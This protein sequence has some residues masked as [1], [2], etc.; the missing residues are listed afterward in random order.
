MAKLV[1]HYGAK[2]S[3]NFANG[4]LDYYNLPTLEKIGSLSRLPFSVRILLESAL[5]NFDAF[6]FTEDHIKQ[7]INWN[8]TDVARKEIPYK[9]ARVVL[10]DFTG[11]PAIV[12]LAAMREAMKKMGGAPSKINPLV[13]C[14]LVID[15]SVQVDYAGR[16]DA[17]SLNEKLEFQRNKERYQ[18]LKWG[19]KAFKNLRVVPP[20]TGI[21]HQVNL[22]YLAEG[23]YLNRDKNLVYPD[24]CVGTDSHTPMVNGLGVLAWGVGGIEAEAVMLDQ[25]LYLLVPDV[26]GIKL[27]GSL[28]E[29][30]T[31]TDLVLKITEVCRKIGVVDKFVEFFG[32]GLESLSV[33]DRATIGNMAPE[34]GSTVSFFPIDDATINYLKF[35]GRPKELVDLTERYTKEQGLFRT[36]DTPDPDF[37]KVVELNLGEI[38]PALAGP[39]RPH[40]RVLLSDL[41]KTFNDVLKAPV[42]PKGFGL[43]EEDLSKTSS[44]RWSSSDSKK[45]DEKINH[46]SVV[47]AA[48]TSCTNTSNPSVMI[49]AGLVAK[50]AVERGMKV[51]K[52]VKTSLAPGSTVVTEYLKAAG[53]LPYLEQLG[54]QVV[55]YGCTTCIGNSGPIEK[56]VES[57]IKDNDLV[58]ASVLSG[59]R[60]FEGRVHPMT[61]ANYLA[62][63]PLVVAYALSGSVAKDISSSPVGV[64]KNGKDVYLKEIWPTHQEIQEAVSKFVTPEMFR[65]KY[66]DV[67]KG[68][69]A[70]QKIQAV[71]GELY[72]WD[73]SSTYIQHPPF[74]E[75]V[76]EGAKEISTISGA[77]VLAVFKDSVTTDHI[78][79]AGDIANGSPAAVYLESLGVSKDDFNSYGSRRGNDRIMVR[80]TFANIRIKNQLLA[81]SEGN[82]TKHFP[83]G[84]QMSFFDAAMKYKLEGTSLIVLAGKEYGSGSSRDWAAKGPYLQ[85][86]KAVIA[87]SYERIHRSNLIGMGIIPLQFKENNSVSS[88]G[89]SGEEIFEITLSDSMKA[90]DDISVSA[91]SKD[92]TAKKFMVRSR[93]DT[94]V[95]LQYFRDGGILRTVLMNIKEAS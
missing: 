53:L 43:T 67:F 47:I 42:G 9:P 75:G 80:G 54:F 11:V 34:Q 26:I 56:E 48:I 60:N 13:R 8:P 58:A 46:G 68:S 63:P 89:L 10:Q 79:P 83:S 2:K 17:L 57:A 49:A 1:D 55:G 27:V 72:N 12:D 32:P 95:E 25:P 69:E 15:H 16:S 21:V 64:D 30:I 81:G 29:G 6:A 3:I 39:K 92:G 24:S 90:G 41:G 93:I 40:D 85:G 38:E 62:S 71:E 50:K 61:R 18:F 65:S 36:K 23:I 37:T 22:E 87:E 88:L 14:D 91:V 7:I 73:D 84:Q 31:A 51:K 19:Q 44:V 5:R 94:G 33:S 45:E 76:E 28:R 78:S 35:T 52:Y 66:A 70:W 77:R 74:F 20:S 59:N 86:I 82:I 4:K